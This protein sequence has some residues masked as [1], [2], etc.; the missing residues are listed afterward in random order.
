MQSTPLEIKTNTV[1]LFF[2]PMLLLA[3]NKLYKTVWFLK[4]RETSIIALEL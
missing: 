2:F 1:F 3:L 4:D